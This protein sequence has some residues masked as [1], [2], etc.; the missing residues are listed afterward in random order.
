M[1]KIYLIL[2]VL[3]FNCG[4]DNPEKKI[5]KEYCDL[6]CDLKNNIDDLSNIKN[7]HIDSTFNQVDYTLDR[8]SVLKIENEAINFDSL[9]TESCNC[10]K[11]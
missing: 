2:I 6:I 8:I 3:A 4:N 5:I 1:K 10:L 7:I 11:K 9:N